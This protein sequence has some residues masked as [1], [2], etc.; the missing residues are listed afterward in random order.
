[1]LTKKNRTKKVTEIYI[2]IKCNN[3]KYKY[4]KTNF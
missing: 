4:H 2:G 1:M 3:F